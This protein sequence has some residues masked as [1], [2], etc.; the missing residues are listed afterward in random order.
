MTPPVIVESI[1]ALGAT[2]GTRAALHMDIAFRDL[3]RGAGVVRT[4]RY[5]RCITGETHPM[6]NLAIVA[7]PGDPGATLEA[8]EPLVTCGAPAAA[9]F[10]RGA[11][12]DVTA[13]VKAAGF[14]VETSM[15]AMA[16]DIGRM[17]ATAL[18]R[19]YEWTRVGAG[20]DG[21]AWTDALAVGYEI[22]RRLAEVFSPESLGA[23]MAPDANIQYFAILRDGRPVA[24]SLL[25]LADGLAGIYCV[26]TLPEERHKGLGAHVT[27]G[28]LRIAQGLGYRVGVLQSSTAGYLV[29]RRLGF[30][31]YS[32]VPM[33]IHQPGK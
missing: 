23:D 26:A 31:D 20:D 24:T 11:T 33:F 15:P 27:A 25:Y 10:P 21:R 19:G 16:V 1:D 18:P 29:Y 4:D 6:G 28:A 17:A 8:I 14:A 12:A 13:A 7:D 5:M 32:H 9:I 3:M 30:G 22:S 2:V